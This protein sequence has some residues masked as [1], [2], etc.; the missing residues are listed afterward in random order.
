M[1]A[2]PPTSAQLGPTGGRASPTLRSWAL[3]VAV[4]AARPH[5][6]LSG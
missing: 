1:V 5:C 2:I 4:W 3:E 6:H